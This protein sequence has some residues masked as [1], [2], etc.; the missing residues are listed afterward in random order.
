MKMRGF[1]GLKVVQQVAKLFRAWRSD[2]ILMKQMKFRSLTLY[3]IKYQVRYDQLL[4]MEGVNDL[5]H[6]L[7]SLELDAELPIPDLF[8]VESIE[9]TSAHLW[10]REKGWIPGFRKWEPESWLEIFH[11]GA[12]CEVGSSFSILMKDAYRPSSEYIAR[13]IS[14]S[15]FL[16]GHKDLARDLL[17]AFLQ[18]LWDDPGEE[19]IPAD[20]PRVDDVGEV[21]RRV[22][23]KYIS[24]LRQIKKFEVKRIVA[25]NRAFSKKENFGLILQANSLEEFR[26]LKAQKELEILLV[27]EEQRETVQRL[28]SDVR[29]PYWTILETF[30]NFQEWTIGQNIDPTIRDLKDPGVVEVD[31]LTIEMCKRPTEAA[32]LGHFTHCCQHLQSAGK[33]CVIAGLESPYSGFLTVKKEGFILAQSW[34]W[35]DPDKPEGARQLVLDSIESGVSEKKFPHLA[36]KI[37]KAYCAFAEKAGVSLLV[38][39]Y[40]TRP[41]YIVCQ[42]FELEKAY[43]KEKTGR[44]LINLEASMYLDIEPYSDVDKLWEIRGLGVLT[45]KQKSKGGKTK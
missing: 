32:M 41:T 11:I 29:M 18:M 8:P 27:T 3:D 21:P 22:L 26:A 44:M 23:D 16:G 45:N 37:A 30:K 14:W 43:D 19:L 35:M 39:R 10:M 1:K 6:L 4:R 2:A 13:A 7:W 12:P 40:A 15:R 5:L 28:R 42:H 36:G 20:A 24:W 17:K 38:N 9:L 33:F 31:G 25:L 34:V